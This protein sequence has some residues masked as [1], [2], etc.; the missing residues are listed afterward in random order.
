[1]IQ[2]NVSPYSISEVNKMVHNA[3]NVTTDPEWHFSYRNVTKWVAGAFAYYMVKM[4]PFQHYIIFLSSEMYM[5][6]LRSIRI[7]WEVQ[8]SCSEMQCSGTSPT[9][10]IAMSFQIK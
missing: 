9:V 6:P 2:K 3:K 5:I 10:K 7:S 1:M 4:Q 8:K